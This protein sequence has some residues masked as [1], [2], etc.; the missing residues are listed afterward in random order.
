MFCSQ[1]GDSLETQDR[2]CSSCG[3][4]VGGGDEAGAP[5]GPRAVADEGP[6]VVLRPRFE[7]VLTFAQLLPIQL[8]MTV[9]GGGFFGGF[10]MFAVQALGLGLPTWSTFV[11]FGAVFFLGIPLV[12]FRAA[13]SSAEKTEYR[14]FRDKLE[15]YEGFFTV[16]E[17]SI[18]LSDVTE[19]SLLKGPFQ[20]RYGL[21][22]VVLATRAGV[23]SSRRPGIRL[24]NVEDPDTVYANVKEL[25]ER[26]RGGR[27][28]RRAA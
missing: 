7:P 11:F 8:F 4:R 25:V 23:V 28:L 1:C 14:V 12:A 21:G 24:A 18:A 16:E 19:V 9:W 3:A 20:S 22:T 5:R 6:A 17:K 27:G 13:R 15:Y 2:F 26:A 10:S